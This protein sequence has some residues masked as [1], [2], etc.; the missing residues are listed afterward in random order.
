MKN[1]AYEI[2]QR[3]GATSY[4]IGL[5]VT[6]I[7]QAILRDQN[8]VMTVSCLVGGLYG[9]EDV[10][11]SLPAVVNRQGVNRIVQLSL[12]SEEEQQFKHSAQLL[13][14]AIEELQL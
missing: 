5:A 10:Y 13:R 14:Q 11:L 8:R 1:A 7:A 12:S 2:I 3:K 4:A 6:Q 9:I